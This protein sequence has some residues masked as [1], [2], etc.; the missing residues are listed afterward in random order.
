MIPA[1]GLSVGDIIITLGYAAVGDGGD[2]AYEVVAA[3]TGT[4]EIS[5]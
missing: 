1:G 5:L 4:D 2:N 3:G